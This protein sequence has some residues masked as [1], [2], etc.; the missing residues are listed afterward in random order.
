MA[1]TPADSEQFS[2]RETARRRDEALARALSTPPKLL[3]EF[4]GSGARGAKRGKSKAKKPIKP[5]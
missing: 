4:V 3:S 5:R 1:K 2:E